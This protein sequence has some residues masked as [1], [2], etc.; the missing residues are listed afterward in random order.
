MALDLHYPAT[1]EITSTVM[2]A[3]VYVQYRV[4]GLAWVDPQIL[5]THAL[6][7]YPPYRVLHS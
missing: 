1:M 3:V 6:L 2:D 5:K 4:G 7:H